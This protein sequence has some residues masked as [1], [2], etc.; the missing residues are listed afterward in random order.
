MK[1]H[2]TQGW[3]LAVKHFKLI[4]MLFLYQL[5]WGF[6]LYRYIDSVVT[7]LLRRIPG[8]A[9]SEHASQVF[10]TEAQF[11][12]FKTNL[13]MPYLWVL[14]AF[15]LARMIISPL[16]QAGLLYSINHRMQGES[17]GHFLEGIRKSWKPIMLLYWVEAV[18]LR[19]GSFLVPSIPF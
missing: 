16:F 14:G 6:F 8:A 10:V 5:L 9:P 13:V 19:G 2:M 12:L 15:F 4:T 18:L 7:P 11:L 17:S 1:K 3:K